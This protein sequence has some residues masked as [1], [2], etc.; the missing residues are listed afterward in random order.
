MWIQRGRGHHS[1][2]PGVACPMT[3][4]GKLYSYPRRVNRRRVSESLI[5]GTRVWYS[6]RTYLALIHNV[7]DIKSR[8]IFEEGVV[9]Y[10]NKQPSP[11]LTSR[12]QEDGP[13]L[14][15]RMLHEIRLRFFRK[16]FKSGRELIS[17]S[18]TDMV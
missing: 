11:P 17:G 12:K 13:L 1:W 14:G 7:H 5:C 2:P 6:A 15:H 18:L 8:F 10:R 9:C 16:G 3:I 4:R